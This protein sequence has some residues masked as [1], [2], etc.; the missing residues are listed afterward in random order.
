MRDI[1]SRSLTAL[2][3]RGRLLRTETEGLSRQLRE[4][5]ETDRRG[6]TGRDDSDDEQDRF[7]GPQANPA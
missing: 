4:L 2:L 5:R 1:I 7:S 6:I 3:E